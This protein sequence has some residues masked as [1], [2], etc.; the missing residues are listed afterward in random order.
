VQGETI[1]KQDQIAE[2]KRVTWTGLFAN[3][4]LSALKFLGGTFGNSQ[5]VVADAVHSLSDISTDAAILLGVK[6]WTRPADDS[7]PHGHRQVETLVTLSIGIA[8]A[9]VA[10][11]LLWNAV[12]T[13]DVDR[14]A[15]PGWMA[16]AA[17]LVS[18][19]CKEVLY[20]WTSAVGQRIR[21]MPIIA[22]AWHH[23]SDAL[24]SIPVVV[25]VAG[26]AI[27]PSWAFLDH[28]GAMAVSLFIFQAAFKIIWPT[29]GKLRYVMEMVKEAV[30]IAKGLE[31]SKKIADIAMKQGW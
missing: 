6:H 21:S 5:A 2:I 31:L 29:F 10:G 20:R 4:G 7:H 19:V 14:Q 25:T 26:A 12:S 15:A 3:L 13:L 9:V 1:E 18:I 11:G 28:L 16:F 22:N 8:L 17:A 24:S 23:R 30:I 27:V